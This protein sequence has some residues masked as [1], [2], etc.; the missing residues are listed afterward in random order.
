VQRGAEISAFCRESRSF[1]EKA[2]QLILDYLRGQRQGATLRELC[3]QIGPRLGA[4]PAPMNLEL[5]YAFAGHL[6]DLTS[7][8]VITENRATKPFTYSS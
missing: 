7:R 3:L 1:V 8:N 2:E 5:C 6:A 4:W